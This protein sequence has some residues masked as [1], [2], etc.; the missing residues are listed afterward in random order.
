MLK[1]VVENYAHVVPISMFGFDN[2]IVNTLAR[3]LN[4]AKTLGFGEVL[5]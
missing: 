2:I 1:K 3:Y 5:K 4:H